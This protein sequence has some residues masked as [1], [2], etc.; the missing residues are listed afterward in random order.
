MPSLLEF[1]RVTQDEIARQAAQIIADSKLL[2][3]DPGKTGALFAEDA[4]KLANAGGPVFKGVQAR[5]EEYDNSLERAGFPK[6]LVQKGGPFQTRFDLSAQRNMVTIQAKECIN[7]HDSIA[8]G[9]S[10]PSSWAVKLRP[11]KCLE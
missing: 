8:S 4:T 9:N 6:I 5:I 2:S 3:I 10:L 11:G 7:H 1:G